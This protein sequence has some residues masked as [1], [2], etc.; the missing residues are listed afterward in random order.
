MEKKEKT[1]SDA[2]SD[3]DIARLE[4]R[5]D[6]LVR[7]FESIKEVMRQPVAV[8]TIDSG[9]ISG[10]ERKV[11][12]LEAE[13]AKWSTERE[14]WSYEIERGDLENGRLNGSLNRARSR[15]AQLESERDFLRQALLDTER[16]CKDLGRDAAKIRDERDR[17]R[18]QVAELDDENRSLSRSLG[19]SRARASEISRVPDAV[20][21]HRHF[22]ADEKS[23]GDDNDRVQV[24]ARSMYPGAEGFTWINMGLCDNLEPWHIWRRPEKEEAPSDAIAKRS[25]EIMARED[26]VIDL[27]LIRRYVR[28]ADALARNMSFAEISN[29]GDDE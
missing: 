23:P 13:R 9:T 12:T 17:L 19:E 6:A 21:G 1:M 27:G 8:V 4:H 22:L 14:M 7:S 16:Q 3:L 11:E 25:R 20:A 28:R 24:L 10:L 15:A 2:K 5:M 29:D 18:E 26:V